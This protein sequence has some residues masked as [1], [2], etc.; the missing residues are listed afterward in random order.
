MRT[1]RA[2]F[3]RESDAIAAREQLLARGVQPQRVSIINR[4][5]PTRAEA[6]DTGK[7]RGLWA[8]IK[9]LVALPDEDRG[10]FEDRVT[11][12]GFLLTASLPDTMMGEAMA[13]LEKH[14]VVELGERPAAASTAPGAVSATAE[15]QRIPVMEENLHVGTRAVEGD[16]VR[17]HSH[18]AERPAHE[19]VR[20]HDYVVRIERRR[21]AGAATGGS[22]EDLFTERDLQMTETREEVRFDK[23]ARVREE[24]VVRREATERVEE[25]DTTL[26]HTEVEVERVPSA[27]R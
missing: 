7:G 6:A 12:G 27:P 14:G 20:L 1:V 10:S 18:A 19:R 16:K 26:R 23:V 17:I 22:L 25:I 3:D 13:T 15:E 21:A 9:D 8:G 11:R 24:V 4:A 2:M 5:R